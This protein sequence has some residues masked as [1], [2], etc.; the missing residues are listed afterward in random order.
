MLGCRKGFTHICFELYQETKKKGYIQRNECINC[1]VFPGMYVIWKLCER[2]AILDSCKSTKLSKTLVQ[3]KL[4][5]K[6]ADIISDKYTG[7]NMKKLQKWG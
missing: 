1:L 7:I 4:L 3:P 6:N 2:E 5:P